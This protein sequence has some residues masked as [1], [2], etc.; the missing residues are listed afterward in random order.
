MMP[1][2]ALQWVASRTKMCSHSPSLRSSSAAGQAAAPLRSARG[3]RSSA[4]SGY[5]PALSMQAPPSLADLRA[6]LMQAA[7]RA[8]DPSPLAPP[9]NLGSSRLGYAVLRSKGDSCGGCSSGGGGSGHDDSDGAQTCT[10]YDLPSTEAG[11]DAAGLPRKMLPSV[12][13]LVSPSPLSSKWRCDGRPSHR[14]SEGGNR[15][16]SRGRCSTIGKSD[17]I[18]QHA[19]SMSPSIRSIRASFSGSGGGETRHQG[20]N[21]SKDCSF[22]IRECDGK[23]N[24]SGVHLPRLLQGI[25]AAQTGIASKSCPLPRLTDAMGR[26]CDS[27]S[28]GDPD[29][30]AAQH[31]S[32]DCTCQPLAVPATAI[33]AQQQQRRNLQR[34]P[35]PNSTLLTELLKADGC[36]S[37]L[38]SMSRQLAALRCSNDGAPP[39]SPCTG[40]ERA[41]RNYR[42]QY[43]SSHDDEDTVMAFMEV[44]PW[45][46]QELTGLH[47]G[48]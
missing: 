28:S 17:A 41:R 36:S 44:S 25:T 9:S 12:C 23:S 21:N 45:G 40:G 43:S 26:S 48:N 10:A 13:R 15:E 3:R 33:A 34:S 8:L 16:Q 24:H 27:P 42:K 7:S 20:W 6:R 18:P 38:Q 22:K 30:L 11:G 14:V 5:V 29:H 46:G 35:H 39:A 47:V 31:T 19:S 32:H 37:T 4:T 1:A 2:V